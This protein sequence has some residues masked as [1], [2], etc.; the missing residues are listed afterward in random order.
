MRSPQK[1]RETKR[2]RIYQ[3]HRNSKSILA[4]RNF[5]WQRT[6]FTICCVRRQAV[7]QCKW[8]SNITRE[9]I[10]KWSN[11]N[12]LKF[13][14]RISHYHIQLKRIFALEVNMCVWHT[15]IIKKWRKQES[16]FFNFRHHDYFASVS[17]LFHVIFSSLFPCKH[18][19]LCANR[20]MLV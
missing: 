15:H 4:H 12:E 19:K 2:F 20:F 18:T 14:W 8:F 9:M 1:N 3:I 10:S 11:K 13:K 16:H 5:Q 6:S 17:I 7:S